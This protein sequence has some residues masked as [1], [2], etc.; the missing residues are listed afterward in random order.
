MHKVVA[1]LG[2]FILLFMEPTAAARTALTFP[3]GTGLEKCIRENLFQPY[4]APIYEEDALTLTALSCDGDNITSLEG[5]EPFTN[6]QSIDFGYKGTAIDNLTPLASLNKL[7]RINISKSNISDI[8]PLSSLL[9]VYLNLSDNH[10]ADLSPLSGITTL[11]T[12]VLYRQS[13]DYI[14]DISPLSGL[15][16]LTLLDLESNKITDIAP[17]QNMKRLRYLHLKDNRLT[18]IEPLAGINTLELVNLSLNALTDLTPLAFSPRI[19]AL[20]ADANRITSLDFV[21]GLTNI[22]H[23]SLNRNRIT[24]L[25]PLDNLSDPI[26]LSFDMNS[27]AEIEILRVPMTLRKIKYLS[28]AYNCIQDFGTL[29]LYFINEAHLLHQCQTHPTPSAFDL[30]T[31][32][33]GDLL[34]SGGAGDGPGGIGDELMEKAEPTGPGGCS[35][36]ENSDLILILIPLILMLAI[37]R[38]RI[39]R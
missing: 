28:L 14:T 21:S 7:T 9:L 36:A 17:L 8:S 30:A 26:Y 25:A 32:V 11:S 15:T 29:P 24:S 37:L 38:G 35:L 23:I 10:I 2:F 3:K 19:T 31:V 22:T 6:L 39:R 20:Y 12:L 34:E 18:S 33:N 27:I 4:L 16:G 5:I 13:P 1:Y